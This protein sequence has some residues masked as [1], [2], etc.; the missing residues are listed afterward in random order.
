VDL[1]R[2]NIEILSIEDGSS[3]GACRREA[4][5][6]AEDLGFAKIQVEEIAISVTEMVT[7]VLNHGGGKGQLVLCG[8]QDD[9]DH[10][11]LEIWCL[12]Y[13]KGILNTYL[14]V[15][16]GYSSMNSLG[17]GIGS[18]RR[19]SDE[20][21]INPQD[22]PES[23]KSILPPHTVIGTCLYLRK[24]LKE[25]TLISVNKNLIIGAA[26]RPKPGET[27]NGDCYIVQHL[28][29][30]KSL[31]AVIDGLGHGFTS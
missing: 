28:P 12:D 1:S 14:A 30:G 7:N 25:K 6:F 9:Q 24:W 18:I 21:E 8:I 11:G 17:I 10:K 19:L 2:D 22:L 20:F 15:Q 29:E 31:V 27:F 16:D 23:I 13:G 26:S 4:N 5:Q 3:A